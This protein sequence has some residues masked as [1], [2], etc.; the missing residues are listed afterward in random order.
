MKSG[1][2]GAGL[3]Y[4]QNLIKQNI[5]IHDASDIFKLLL[6]SSMKTEIK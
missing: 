5:A 6:W 3:L 4:V 2:Y 1:G